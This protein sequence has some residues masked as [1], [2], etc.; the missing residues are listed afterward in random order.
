MKR[1]R[2]VTPEQREQI[3]V[4][5]SVMLQKNV[6]KELR[7]SRWTIAKIQRELG[8]SPHPA[9]P[10]P[11]EMEKKVVELLNKKNYGAPKIAAELAVPQHKVQAIMEKIRHKKPQGTIGHRYHLGE[12]ELRAIRREIRR[13]EGAIAKQFGVSHAWLRRFRLRMWS[14][15]GE[16]HW[17]RKRRAVNES[18]V[19]VKIATHVL[20]GGKLPDRA[21][22]A[23]LV[24]AM[25][26]C[27]A[28]QNIPMEYRD[29]LTSA[30]WQK[31][32]DSLA[33]HLAEAIDTCRAAQDSPWK[34]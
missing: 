6:A 16:Q 23:R 20:G 9:E 34:N 22:D 21:F 24:A 30:G 19:Y 31:V 2:K 26:D 15:S 1:T 18:D 33:A 25:V 28:P 17:K 4:L 13:S 8:L 27:F 7:L 10:L 3:R 29:A 12:L 5:S 11:K 32:R 14:N